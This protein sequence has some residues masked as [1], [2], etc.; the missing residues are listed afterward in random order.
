MRICAAALAP[1]SCLLLIA[2]A[3]VTG[4]QAQTTARING[5][6]VS[7]A[8]GTPV[9][10]AAVTLDPSPSDQKLDHTAQTDPFG[11][12]ELKQIAPGNYKFKVEHPHFVPIEE[13]AVLT[14]GAYTNRVFR[15]SPID[16][17]VFFDIHFQVWCL[18]TH[19]MLSG[20]TIA[21]EYWI[22]DGD[23]AGPP[24][25]VFNALT[26]VA[27]DAT[28]AGVKE[29]F[30]TFKV[31]KTGWEPLPYT[32]P[33][34][35][36]MIVVGNKVRLNRYHFGSVFLRPIK[37][38]LSVTVKGY[39]PVKDKPDLPLKAMT[40]K[41]TGVDFAN[42]NL[43]L[44]PTQAAVSSQ[45][46]TY[47]FGN[48]APIR[49]KVEVGRLGYVPKHVFVSA[50]ANGALPAQTLNVDLEPTKVKVV[51]GAPY[52]TTDAVKGA[53]V[54]LQGIR[55]SNTEGI[56]R[57]LD[58][59]PDAAGHT[60]S[61][62]FENLLPG[63]YWI[64]VLHRA[65]ISSL[66]SR[67][68]P[69]FGPNAFEVT[70]FPKETYAEV[71]VGQ[72]EQVRVD[73]E[74]VPARVRGRL[75]ATDEVAN[76]ETEPCDSEENRVFH[77]I[78]QN[79]IVFS[80]HKLIKLLQSTNNSVTVDTDASG[81]Y[82]A[83]V[84][85]GIFGVQ[86]PT[87]TEYTGHNIEFGDLS[88]GRGP[89]F[90]PWPYPDIWPYP[91]F[92]G[93][94]HG[95]GLR[96]DSAHEY[97]LD[98]F[99]HKQYINLRGI[100]RTQNSP[101]GDLILRMNPD[102]TGVQTI[103]YDHL[104]D[105]GGNVVATGPTTHTTPV[106][107][108][109]SYLLRNLKPGTYSITLNH[110]AY[111]TQ[112]VT[113]AIAPWQP[114]GIL[115]T[116]PPLSPTYFFPGI[117]HCDFEFN[118]T[119]EWKAKGSINVNYYTWVVTDDPHY[120][121]NGQRRPNYFRV[122]GLPDR[123][124]AFAFGDGI[125]SPSYTIWSRHGDGWFSSGGS[126]TAEF[127]A[128]EG[129][130]SDNTPPNQPPSAFTAYTLDLH[131]Y[132][133]SDP[134]LEIPGVTVMF[135]PGNA[136]P[137]GGQV[138]HDGT[139]RA[140]GATH[141]QGQ[142]VFAGHEV[143]VLNYATRLIRVKVFMDRAMVVSGRIASTN[144]PVPGAAVVLRN[145]Y[146][147]PITQ[148][149][150]GPDGAYRFSRITPQA[151][152][153]DVNRRGF[154]PQRKKAT[155]P[156]VQNPDIAVDFTMNLAPAPTIDTFTMNRF[157]L[158]LPGV[159]KSGDATGFNP[160]N[161][162]ERLTATW[163][164][165]AR[166]SDFTI[167]LDGFVQGNETQGPPEQFDVVDRVAEVWLVDRRAFTNAFVNELN[168]K[169]YQTVEPPRPLDYLTV[170]NWL[171]EIISARKNGQP[172]YVVHQLVRRGEAGPGNKFEGKLNLWELPS[173]AFNPRLIAV[174]ESGGVA[175]KDY[176]LPAGKDHLQG[177]NLPQWASALMEVIGVGANFGRF[178]GDIHAHY[179]EGF[180]K[181]GT[182]S[183]VVEG[184]IALDP[185]DLKPADDAYLT[186]KYVLGLELP[187]GEG[188]SATGP[189]KLGPEFLGFKAQGAKAEFDV[190]GKEK[191]V[192]LDI[193]FSAALPSRVEQCDSSYLPVVAREMRA[194]EVEPRLKYSGKFG[195]LETLD[196]DWLG[197]NVVSGFGFVLEAQGVVDIAVRANATP[198]LR[199]IP[200]AGPVLLSLDKSGALT[201]KGVFETTF[202][203]KF[204]VEA[205]THFPQPGGASQT[206][207]AEPQRWSLIG[208]TEV[209]K[210]IKLILR[211]AAGLQLSALRGSAE[212]TLLLQGGA[213]ADAPSVD[214]MLFTIN[215]LGEGP[216]ITKI[217]GAFSVV[218][219]AAVNLWTV[220]FQK[221]WQWDIAR[222]V[223]DRASEPSF[224][225]VPINITYTVI[226]TTT[227]PQQ[228]FLGQPSNLIDRFYEAGS[229]D[230]TEQTRP[231][232]VFTGVDQA[233]G[234]M[235]VMVSLRSG[236]QWAQPVK[237]GSAGG[238]VSVATAPN[239]G[240]G[241]IVVWSEIAQADVGNPY[242]PS[243][244][245]YTVSNADATIW[246]DPAVV[247]A[248]PEAM[249][250]LE[251]VQAGD[252]VL[253]VYL[254]TSE[255]P[256]GD[257]QSVS[258]AAWDG[259]NWT[260]PS[261]LLPPQPIKA[262]DVAGNA[263][264]QAVAVAS[265][266]SGDLSSYLWNG[267]AW[268]APKKIGENAEATLSVQ[269]AG[270]GQ[271]VLAWQH[272]NGSIAFST[273][274]T[275]GGNWTE[276]AFPIENV[277]ADDCEV[278]PLTKE[279]ETLHLVAWTQGGEKTSLWY[280][281]VDSRGTLRLPPT[282]ATLDT[283]GR[284]KDLH[285]RPLEGHRAAIIAQY[286]TATNT[287]V[288]EL[289]VG[290]PSAGDCDGDGISDAAELAAGSAQDC[291]RNGVPDNCDITQ[292]TSQDRNHNGIPD[293]CEAPPA[294]DCNR[295][296]ISDRYELALGI[297]DL[298]GNGVLDDCEA[299]AQTKVVPLPKDVSARYYR[300]TRLS[301]KSRTADALEL[302]Y[303]GTLEQAD[304]VAGPW[305]RVP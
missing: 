273:L 100:V 296:G 58:A 66:P 225:L 117:T 279:G 52:Q 78:A 261:Q 262:L 113:V 27:G 174:T 118:L 171:G 134:S 157:G 76:L 235:I 254:S 295:N 245:K 3:C 305:S 206:R 177:L 243:S 96:L 286:A 272:N 75:W 248:S 74:P 126:G 132:S 158:F 69:L 95:A 114:P 203:S 298:N 142:W 267:S 143:E 80:E 270:S 244:V 60:A 148:M 25:Q 146:G 218:L 39:D 87:M 139:P 136:R 51:I 123:L 34:N 181:I 130:P 195:L 50:D 169:S 222:F 22:P 85:P 176:E 97:Q 277:S 141:D 14:A 44:V 167:T 20:A 188:T 154:I 259:R 287:T 178:T 242:P 145:R 121:A 180:L 166:G 260:T 165:E 125:P 209:K 28:L 294:D 268:S 187:F 293:E 111:D 129:G 257:N 280:A 67:S 88:A 282:E 93:G 223:V 53:H 275:A 83:L 201:I 1:A 8:D 105:T 119:A 137:A 204:K 54:R 182:V 120:V 164:S 6:V 185:L 109:N 221:Q 292:G 99:V 38:D 250:G 152:Y 21:A 16:A 47:T 249:F 274:D 212:G 37:Q 89:Q 263:N 271:A 86:I 127:K 256:L 230:V 251:L 189:L 138:A 284:F 19:A 9:E 229:L 43:T 81:G 172:Y 213:P 35:S 227:A 237:L 211:L 258:S 283:A 12:F 68:G 49:W 265:I 46:G 220:K 200:Y 155:P 196:K 162:R 300:A 226:N 84:P 303:E 63:R 30:Y 228:N 133:R 42:D 266:G 17:Q 253:L 193:V 41:L 108:G 161:A 79:G 236:E 299:G 208:S 269:Y 153:I 240:G 234:Q 107:R 151:V 122:T 159:S 82:T 106:L 110:P 186:Y 55:N 285:L 264:G 198:V 194:V 131:A 219:R 135:G 102:G 103:S 15:L 140:T 48:L 31:T 173:G 33:P 59:Q 11:F 199:F 71:T 7:S 247:A 29:G 98:L 252:R 210:D 65:T 160:E 32:P 72:T 183:P 36:G 202:G 4:V 128:F 255:G 175:V 301:I 170:Q 197:N 104:W 207:G 217:E 24:D 70:F 205:T 214:G 101:F 163:K 241:W 64:H 92:E 276:A 5:R 281:F 224:E 192:T 26:G 144:G 297:G 147:N 77:L 184:R 246:S 23:V 90:G 91:T 62:T 73:L 150:T 290:M 233:T 239:P 61:A 45:A 2:L 216:L 179:G 238:V 231:L 232:M 57:D 191:K 116:V 115:P 40:I 156:S 149:V 289:V 94:H 190:K 112:P 168:Q 304:T 18:A 56:L 215:P 302:Q 13:N 291:N 10:N 278:L 124:F 288:R